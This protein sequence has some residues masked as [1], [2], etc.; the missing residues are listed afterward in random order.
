MSQVTPAVSSLFSLIMHGVQHVV[1]SHTQRRQK[2]KK[3]RT[4][5]LRSSAATIS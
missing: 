4:M 5:I 3:T 1:K 2:E